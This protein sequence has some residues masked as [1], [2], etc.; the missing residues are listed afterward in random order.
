M[1]NRVTP[2]A[3]LTVMAAGALGPSLKRIHPPKAVTSWSQLTIYCVARERML[4]DTA[5]AENHNREQ[6]RRSHYEAQC[7]VSTFVAS[8]MNGITRFV[9]FAL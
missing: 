2:Q 7:I 8:N 5:T 1:E 3:F 9:E 6:Q 4:R